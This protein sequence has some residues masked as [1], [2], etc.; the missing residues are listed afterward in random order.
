MILRLPAGQ[1]AQL[2]IDALAKLLP[3]PDQLAVGLMH[4]LHQQIVLRRVGHARLRGAR[5]G[6]RVRRLPAV[7][8]VLLP[9]RQRAHQVEIRVSVASVLQGRAPG[10]PSRRVAGRRRLGAAIP[11]HRVEIPVTES[12]Q[13]KV[14]LLVPATITPLLEFA[15]VTRTRSV[16]SIN[17]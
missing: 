4:D 1:F 12:H 15:R 10:V 11:P 2:Q 8:T 17:S 9:F 14:A 3:M 13:V 16:L 7:S 5:R 6:I